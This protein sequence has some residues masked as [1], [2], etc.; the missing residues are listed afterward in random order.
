[1]TVE[2][3][4]GYYI[5]SYYDK[6]TR[7]YITTLKDED[8]NQIRDAYYSGNM[9]DRN[10]D[11]Q[12]MKE[13]F[14]QYMNE[15]LNLRKTIKDTKEKTKKAK[16]PALSTLSPILPD[17]AA[18]IATFNSGVGLS[19]DYIG[20]DELIKRLKAMGYKYNYP[21]YTDQ[22]LYEIYIKNLK[23]EETKQAFKKLKAAEKARKQRYKDK[24]SQVKYDEDSDTYSDGGYYKDGIEF[25]SE[26]AAREY[27]GESM[28][29]KF[30]LN[31]IHKAWDIEEDSS[32]KTLNENLNNSHD[33]KTITEGLKYF[34]RKEFNESYNDAGLEALYEGVKNS[35]DQDDIRKLGNFLKKADN[36]DE[37]S[38]Y[39]KGLLSEDLNNKIHIPY[40]KSGYG[41]FTTDGDEVE[42]QSYL[43]KFDNVE[44][45]I[46][47]IYA[48]ILL[49]STISH[50]TYDKVI[51]SNDVN[52]LD[53]I[54]T[55]WLYGNV[56]TGDNFNDFTDEIHRYAMLIDLSK[57]KEIAFG[58]TRIDSRGVRK[59]WREY[60]FDSVLTED[61]DSNKINILADEI[62]KFANDNH[63]NAE[64]YAVS[65]NA[66]TVDIAFEVSGDWKHDHLAFD[67]M[68]DIVVDEHNGTVEDMNEDV[69]DEDG[70][71]NYTSIHTFTIK[72]DDDNTHKVYTKE[73][74]D[75]VINK[76]V[77]ELS[78]VGFIL[79]DSSSKITNNLMGGKHLQVINPGMF[80]PTSETEGEEITEDQAFKFFKDDL[81][82]VESVL[83]QFE[84]DH[85]DKLYITFNFGPN[86]DGVITGGIDVRTWKEI[87]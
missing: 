78:T 74:F 49:H 56:N 67:H 43:S 13:F 34:E 61:F 51:F 3:K 31:D 27:F 76:L 60:S 6:N 21:K 35:L 11:I 10:A 68:V 64:L 75:E 42:L 8:G 79:D 80:Y 24:L 33:F 65:N 62:E 38:T 36:A 47:C 77:N 52:K 72:L 58:D 29:T 50:S 63:V 37:V 20:R 9:T 66:D 85:K 71:D 22:E 55:D 86:K 39:I 28:D 2:L 18:G 57:N 23:A 54:I 69:I 30:Y 7:S 12:Y 70:S 19:E 59:G 26:E 40:R 84:E 32:V 87:I 41:G 48:A 82:E 5:D 25:E 44:G 17:G 45:D 14:N 81:I 4:K 16:L 83:D 73:E 1:M 15:A 53:K 46:G